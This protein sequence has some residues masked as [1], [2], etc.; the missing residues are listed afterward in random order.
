V[1][2]THRLLHIPSVPADALDRI[3]GHFDVK[4]PDTPD[5]ATLLAALRDAG[6]EASAFVV[7]GLPDGPHV[8]TLRDRDAIESMMPPDQPEPW[9]KL[10]VNVLQYGI[11]ED[12]FGID[13]AALRAGGAVGYTQSAD[14]ALQSVTRGDAQL[15]FLLNATPVEQ[16]LAVA[17]EAGRMPQKSTYFQPKL[18]TGLVLRPL[19]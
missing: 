10:D 13:D 8:V 15:A 18:P 9:K 17:D 12:V 14:E 5:V 11:L 4:K 3:A 16:V 1:L 6:A 19:D 7:A 2:P